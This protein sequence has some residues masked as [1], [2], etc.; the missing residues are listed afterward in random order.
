MGGARISSK[1][2]TFWGRPETFRKFSKYFLGKCEKFIILA[3][4]SKKL[5]KDV[6]G[7]QAHGE[8]RKFLEKFE[9][10]LRVCVYDENSIEKLIFNYLWKVCYLK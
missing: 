6:L 4:F 8:N 2:N 9:I 10:V 5:T 3:Y 1:G 7:F